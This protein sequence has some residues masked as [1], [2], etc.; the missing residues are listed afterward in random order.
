ML[1]LLRHGEAVDGRPDEARPL[2]DR[3]LREAQAAGVA[4]SRL[5]VKLDACLASPKRR[6]VQ[7]AQLACA[8]LGVEVTV[9][10]ALAGT[11]YDAGRL[12]VGLGEVLLV[13]HNPTI[14]AAVRTLSGARVHMRPGGVAGIERGELVVLMTPSELSA[15][16]MGAAVSV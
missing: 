4:L 10:P 14:S 11:E 15:I 12:A 9:E 5:G 1:W 16:A 3:G 8:S 7:T 13:A 2:T 6:T